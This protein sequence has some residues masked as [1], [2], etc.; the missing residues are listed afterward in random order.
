MKISKLV[1]ASASPSRQNLMKNAGLEFEIDVSNVDES[2]IKSVFLKDGQIDDL[3]MVLAQ[4]KATDVSKS[5]ADALVI[6]ADQT[7][8]FENKVFDK[9][10]SRENARDQLLMLRAKQH[11]L[12]TAVCVFRNEEILWSYS[13][14]SY[15]TFRNFS[16]EFLGRYLS[17]EGDAVLT[18]VGGYK[19]EGL[20]IQLFDKIE[21][22]FF[23]I[24]GLPLLKL[25][26]FLREY[27]A[28][29]T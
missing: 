6:G 12:E 19:L 1:L 11:Q 8:L 16:P 23:S 13:E 7:L 5:H 17:N 26:Q 2:V 20:G 25:L 24:L 14:S 22:D 21:G 9:P 3:A 27:E 15:L 10:T 4:A 18:S 28:V 29:E